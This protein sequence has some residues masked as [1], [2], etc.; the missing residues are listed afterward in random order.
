VAD[1]IEGSVV[2][3]AASGMRQNG[4]DFGKFGAIFRKQSSYL[5]PAVKHRV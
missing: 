5:P 3:S 2:V 4:R 1:W